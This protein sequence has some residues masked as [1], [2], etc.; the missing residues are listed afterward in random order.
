MI[1][2]LLSPE[3]E[4]LADAPK[5]T[6]DE[7]TVLAETKEELKAEAANADADTTGAVVLDTA[8]APVDPETA[9]STSNK[10]KSARRKSS[11]VPEHKSK[12]LNKKAS[13]AKM[14]HINAQPGEHYFIRL[15]G[16]PPWPGIICDEAMLPQTLLKSRPVTAA[17]PDGTYR[18]DFEDGGKRVTERT[19]PVMYLSTNEL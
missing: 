15:K 12:K 10:S 13:K 2:F 4:P 17:R 1:I 7:P 11:G 8:D 3:A 18:A 5:P 14:T 16:Y 19:F 9:A 6:E